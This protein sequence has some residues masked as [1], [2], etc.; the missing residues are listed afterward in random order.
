MRQGRWR[1][2]IEQPEADPA[3]GTPLTDALARRDLPQLYR[4]MVEIGARSSDLP[5]MLT[6]LAD[7]YHRANAVWTRLKGLMV[8]PLIVILVA[9]AM[10]LVLT[11]VFSHFL[12]NFVG[13]FTPPTAWLASMWIPPAVLAL[14]AVFGI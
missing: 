7:H 14:L 9:L 8:Y 10:T 11:L 6:M 3:R 13:L 4:R 5:T 12:A 2:E 1:S